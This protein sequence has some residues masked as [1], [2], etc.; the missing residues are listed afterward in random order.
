M[1]VEDSYEGAV[2]RLQRLGHAGVGLGPPRAMSRQREET[3][4]RMRDLEEL[5][6]LACEENERVAHE[7]DS[8]RDE[9]DR[10]RRLVVT[11]QE[12][13]A[14][15]QSE[16]SFAARK[17]RGRGLASYFFTIVIVGGAAAALFTLRPWERLRGGLAVAAATAP[18]VQPSAPVV[19]AP[20]PAV[21]KIEVAVPKVEP[22][23]PKV[24]P[25][26]PKVEPAAAAPTRAHRQHA[27][28]H[29][30]KSSR[31]EE[32]KHHTAARSS[33]QP[34]SARTNDPLGGLNL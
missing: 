30:A 1:N 25:T 14:S 29:S 10:L 12:S 24:E 23:V 27:K 18:E 8:A 19:V 5:A 13:V 16:P 7:L 9:I 31:H 21:P 34:Q 11:L 32:H 26:V 15:A 33:N 3:D 22:I 4:D 20:P 17:P 28:H 6:T 2:R